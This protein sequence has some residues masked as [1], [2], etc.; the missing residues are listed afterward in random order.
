M[1]QCASLSLNPWPRMERST[2]MILSVRGFMTASEFRSGRDEVSLGIY[3]CRGIP[4]PYHSA[5]TSFRS[6]RQIVSIVNNENA[7]QP[8]IDEEDIQVNG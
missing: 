1:L 7:V 8:H 5:R 2:C 6:K 4:A 3:R